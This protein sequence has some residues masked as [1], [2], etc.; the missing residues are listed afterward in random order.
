[1]ARYCV[2]QV[3]GR[4][5]AQHNRLYSASLQPA[6]RPCVTCPVSERTMAL[7]SRPSDLCRDQGQGQRGGST[8]KGP[9]HV[10]FTCCSQFPRHKHW[11][12]PNLQV[13]S[14]STSWPGTPSLL[15]SCPDSRH[16]R[17]R[18]PALHLLSFEPNRAAQNNRAYRSPLP[19]VDASGVWS[20]FFFSLHV[21]LSCV[22]YLWIHIFLWS[23]LFTGKKQVAPSSPQ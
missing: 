4:E 5:E 7:L 14:T 1:M 22:F 11:Q 13:I 21:T 10:L 23:E 18:L 15:G 19:F 8:T 20:V 16:L 2:R 17:V 12:S 6:T 3:G 9:R